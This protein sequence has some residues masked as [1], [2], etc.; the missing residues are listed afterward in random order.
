MTTNA[1]GAITARAATTAQYRVAVVENVQATAGQA[2][3]IET[4]TFAF[5]FRKFLSRFSGFFCAQFGYYCVMMVLH[6][7]DVTQCAE[8]G[9]VDGD[10]NPHIYSKRDGW[11]V[12]AQMRGVP[13]APFRVT[14]K[15]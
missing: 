2:I 3:R 5:S 11:A 10:D 13:R 1:G 7:Y 6:A 9:K 15:A 8:R 12:D 14:R 4:G